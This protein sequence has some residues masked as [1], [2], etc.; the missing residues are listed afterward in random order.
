M[1][2]ITKLEPW[3]NTCM[4][5]NILNNGDCYSLGMLG[6]AEASEVYSVTQHILSGRVGKLVALHA[7]GC[8]VARC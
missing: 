5:N 3:S 2:P 1:A 8:K 7:E 6:K 4:Q